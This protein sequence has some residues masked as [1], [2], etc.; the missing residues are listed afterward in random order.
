MNFFTYTSPDGD[1]IEVLSSDGELK[2]AS[3]DALDGHNTY[4]TVDPGVLPDLVAALYRAAGQ[5]VP[6]M[7]NPAEVA[8]EWVH[9]T[10][11]RGAA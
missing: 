2:L 6:V 10:G 4:I 5:T 11:T 1:R 3:S 9:V 8:E 7:L